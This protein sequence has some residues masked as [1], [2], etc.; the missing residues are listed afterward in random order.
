M[1]V[2]VCVC[3]CVCNMSSGAE[4]LTQER[5]I[6]VKKYSKNKIHTICVGPK[7]LDHRNLCHPATT[8]NKSCCSTK[9]PIKKQAKNTKEKCTNGLMMVKVH[10]IS[11]ILLMI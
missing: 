2:C 8:K 6:T 5:I 1:C 10:T 7:S 9:Y 3:V 4:R 11:K